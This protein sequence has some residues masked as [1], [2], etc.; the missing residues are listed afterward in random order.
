MKKYY[1]TK[2][3]CSKGIIEVCEEILKRAGDTF[4]ILKIGLLHTY[5]DEEFVFEDLGLAKKHAF[6]LADK[7]ISSLKDKIKGI[8]FIHDRV[9]KMGDQ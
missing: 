8:N 1:I 3:A 5:I 6:K 4:F 2:Y 7:K 9:I